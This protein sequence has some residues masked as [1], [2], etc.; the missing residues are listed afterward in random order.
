MMLTPDFERQKN[1]LDLEHQRYLNYFNV[2]AATGIAITFS[3]IWSYFIDKITKA[4]FVVALLI[5]MIIFSALL[6]AT[7]RKMELTREKIKAL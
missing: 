5:V 4:L 7:I 6:I 2:F 1:L 3:I